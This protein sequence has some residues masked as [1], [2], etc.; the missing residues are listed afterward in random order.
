MYFLFSHPSEFAFIQ[1]NSPCP[2]CHVILSTLELESPWCFNYR[3]TGCGYTGFSGI[4]TF[5]LSRPGYFYIC[6]YR[7]VAKHIF[8]L[9]VTRNSTKPCAWGFKF[10]LLLNLG[11]I[12]EM[13][14]FPG[15]IYCR[16]QFLLFNLTLLQA[17]TIELFFFFF[18]ISVNL[19]VIL[20]ARFSVSFCFI[21]C[22]L[23]RPHP[24]QRKFRKPKR[25]FIR[26]LFFVSLFPPSPFLTFTVVDL[27]EK[28][29]ET[30]KCDQK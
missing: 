5:K 22:P 10:N 24:L 6:P 28:G 23:P 2:H 12:F 13:H 19:R 16:S 25:L 17:Q 18:Q 4:H 15:Y 30:C 21:L 3:I 29:E 9:S 27:Q 1:T 20:Q 8:I 7:M 11:V 26:A 14:G